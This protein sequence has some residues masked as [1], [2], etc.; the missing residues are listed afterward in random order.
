MGGRSK[1][2][3]IQ[4]SGIYLNDLNYFHHPPFSHTHT[5]LL[6]RPLISAEQRPPTCVFVCVCRCVFVRVAVKSVCL[7]FFVFWYPGL[8]CKVVRDGIAPT[9]T[10]SAHLSR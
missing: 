5:Q 8:V 1:W 4:L 6:I 9:H 3:A 7:L 10:F 2:K